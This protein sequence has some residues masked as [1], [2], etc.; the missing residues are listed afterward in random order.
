MQSHPV[1]PHGW[2]SVV[3]PILI[4][5]VVMLLRMRRMRRVR[6]LRLEQLWIVPA[7]YAVVVIAAVCAA[8]AEALGGWL[9]S[10]DRA[11]SPAVRSAGS[12]AS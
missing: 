12:E 2:I 11:W 7:L 5:A 1:Q 3:V 10:D 6:P 4:V 8:P 9:S